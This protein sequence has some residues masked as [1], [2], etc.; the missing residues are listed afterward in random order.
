MLAAGAS[1]LGCSSTEGR[2][3]VETSDDDYSSVA[4]GLWALDGVAEHGDIELLQLARRSYASIVR[5]VTPARAPSEN[6]DAGTSGTG[7]APAETRRTATGDLTGVAQADGPATISLVAGDEEL[8]VAEVGDTLT[9]TGADG[10][11]LTY[12]RSYRLYCVPT[13]R[14]IEATFLL[15]LG[16]EPT[17]VAVNGD[18]HS[19]PSAGVH[20]ATVHTDDLFRLHEY[21]IVSDTGTASVKVKLAWADMSKSEV[22]GTFS[23]IGPADASAPTPISC[24]RVFPPTY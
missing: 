13:D 11:V 15:E 3:I 22:E 4:N 23:L 17:L 2:T 21:V 24:E 9:L 16:K 7:S 14:G 20:A 5:E 8:S 12:R 1:W 19:F 18:G 6:A 10:R